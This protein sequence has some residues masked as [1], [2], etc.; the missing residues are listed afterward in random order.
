MADNYLQFSEVILELTRDESAWLERQLE[1]IAVIDTQV[2]PLDKVPEHLDAQLATYRGPRFLRGAKQIDVW[3][4]TPDFNAE[5]LDEQHN[6]HHSRQ[7]WLYSEGHG[8]LEQVA[9]LVQSFLRKFRPS[10][11]W[12]IGYA[13]T[14]SIPRV[15]PFGGGVVIV[16]AKRVRWHDSGAIAAKTI[17][18]HDQRRRTA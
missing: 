18:A 9:L 3:G 2:Y 7:L 10:D 15:G 12:T 6:G 16:T 14:C 11:I 1:S 13:A 4:D 8:S 17:K 5:F